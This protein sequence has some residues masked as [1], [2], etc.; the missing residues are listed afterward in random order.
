MLK[1]FNPSNHKQCCCLGVLATIH[2]DIEIGEAEDT[3]T[4]SCFVDGVSEKYYP[5]NEMGIHQGCE[6]NLASTNDITYAE[7]IR[8]YSKVI[9]LIEKLKTVD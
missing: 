9:P 6:L 7:G 4:G 2:P 8:D 1:I 3:S 5:F